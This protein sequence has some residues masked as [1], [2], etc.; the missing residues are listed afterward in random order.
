MQTRKIIQ[1]IFGILLLTGILSGSRVAKAESLNVAPVN[2][3][4]F[5]GEGCPHCAKEREFLDKIKNEYGDQIEIHQ[6]EIYYNPDNVKI[7][8]EVSNR[9]GVQVA[10]VPF[11]VIGDREI[12]GYGGDNTT[13]EEIRDRINYCLGGNC[14]DETLGIIYP[15]RQNEERVLGEESSGN[16]AINDNN[17]NEDKSN[18]LN[19]PIVGSVDLADLSL[20]V[21]TFLIALMDGFNPCAMWILVFL[22]TMLVNMK[23]KKRLYSLG[24]IFIITSGAVYFVFLAAWLNFFKF[25]GYVYWIKVIIGLVAMVCGALHLRDAMKKEVVCHVVNQKGRATIMQ[26]IKNITKEKSFYLA[27]VGIVVLAV[28][29]NMV[30]LVCSAGLPAVYTNLLSSTDLSLVEHYL[31]LL[32][33]TLI[34]MLDDLIIFFVAIKTFEISGISQK[35]TRWSSIIGGIVIF[36]IGVILIV[37]PDLLMFG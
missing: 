10:G 31:Y 15:E 26:R 1:I 18:V 25:V 36:V 4:I 5:Y 6:F 8:N 16:E 37:K 20:P 2:I 21:A 35:Y 29:V 19:V 9:L 17:S 33:Y 7:I 27:V 34:F 24:S 28:S 32:F 3:Y 13:G 23:N 12:I 22:I 14:P 30:E 11:L